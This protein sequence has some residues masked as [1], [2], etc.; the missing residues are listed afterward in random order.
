[1]TWRIAFSS[2]KFLPTLPEGCQVSPGCYGFEL[3][4]WLAQG[5][6]RDGVLTGYPCEE[7]WGWCLAYR[8]SEEVSLTIG[9]AS[10]CVAGAGY[11]GQPV[12][13]SIFVRERRSLEQRILRRSNPAAVDQLASR[14]IALLD[15]EQ[16]AVVPAA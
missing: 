5:L 4:L 11:G 15:A 8:P 13:W 10:T 6:S 14:I 3:A 7:D 9:C 12:E 2:D 1:M 16:I